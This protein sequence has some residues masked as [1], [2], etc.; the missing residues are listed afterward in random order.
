MKV[1]GLIAKRFFGA[2]PMTTVAALAFALAVGGATFGTEA[3]LPEAP[4]DQVVKEGTFS[5]RWSTSGSWEGFPVGSG[6][7][8]SIYKSTGSIMSETGEGPFHNMSSRC[9]GMGDSARADTGH[10]VFTDA[11]QDK[12]FDE[13][14]YDGTSGTG[15]IIGGTGKYEGIQGFY[16]Y[17]WV[18]VP[19]AKDGTYQGYSSSFSGS[20][21]LP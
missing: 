5:A 19:A 1:S 6:R 8:V 12:I 17:E 4:A 11:D 7:W 10:C 13:W 15:S 2:R 16:E 20:W 21:T 18:S 3:G 14:T 9:I